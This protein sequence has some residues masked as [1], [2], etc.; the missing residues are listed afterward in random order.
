MKCQRV[1]IVASTL[2]FTVRGRCLL[3]WRNRLAGKRGWAT[4]TTSDNRSLDRGDPPESVREAL[5][6]RNDDPANLPRRWPPTRDR[7]ASA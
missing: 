7:D 6:R 3:A 4:T 2:A 1:P 5:G